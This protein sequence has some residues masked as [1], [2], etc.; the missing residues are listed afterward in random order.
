MMSMKSRWT[1]EENKTFESALALFEEESPERW[2]KI[3]AMIPTKSVYDVID[4][5]TQLVS[6]VI[7]IETGLVPIPAYLSF[8]ISP[9]RSS[10]SHCKKGLPWTE[11]E[12]RRFLLGL[13]KHGKGDWK[14][15]SRNFVV[16]KTP[17]Q[18]ASHAQKY[19]MRQLN[20]DKDKRRPSIHD[21]SIHLTGDSQRFHDDNNQGDLMLFDSGY[22]HGYP[23]TESLYIVHTLN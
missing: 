1:N 18:V 13:E 6:D 17:T 12:H 16:S 11:P 5:Y 9:N 14:N 20:G 7:D 4:Q 22:S 21:I 3:A 15:I 2:F 23:Y 10:P 19:Y 8:N